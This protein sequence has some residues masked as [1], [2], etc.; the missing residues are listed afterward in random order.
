MVT[1][2][3]INVESITACTNSSC[4]SSHSGKV[5]CESYLAGQRISCKSASIQ[6]IC[7]KDKSDFLFTLLLGYTQMYTR[8]TRLPIPPCVMA[9]STM[10]SIWG[11]S[12]FCQ[13]HTQKQT[14]NKCVH[15]LLAPCSVLHVFV[16]SFILQFM[17]VTH[18]LDEA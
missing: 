17:Q 13:L 10:G 11:S 7:I 14:Q 6:I 8:D 16:F 3:Y 2:S 5:S 15:D 18:A 4:H 9:S 1:A 12:G